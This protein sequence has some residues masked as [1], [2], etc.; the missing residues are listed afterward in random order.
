LTL[1]LQ[2]AT[3]ERVRDYWRGWEAQGDES[4]SV[5]VVV[6]GSERFVRA[7]DRL[8]GRVGESVIDLR[9]LFP[10]LGDHVERV[11][12]EA[13]L[14]YAD[15]ASLRLVATDGVVDV[16][17]G[18][19][20]LAALEAASDPLEW[21]EASV[22][23]PCAQRLGVV[24]CGALVALSTVQLWAGALGHISVFTAAPARARGLGARAGSAAVERALGLGVVPQW[25]SRVGN[26]ASERAADGLGFVPLGRQFTV[27]LRARR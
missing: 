19:A 4:D 10:L 24:E 11:V 22:D 16:D 1:S 8:H 18:D 9:S 23:E 17:D 3:V 5:S 2:A 26:L 20:R 15:D 7:P 13:R 12:G 27:R 6:L 21:S 14:A 25:R